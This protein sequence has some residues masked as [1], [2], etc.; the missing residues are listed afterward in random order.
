LRLGVSLSGF[1][2][3]KICLATWIADIVRAHRREHCDLL[4]AKTRHATAAAAD[5]AR[6]DRRDPGAASAVELTHFGLV[7][8]AVTLRGFIAV[9]E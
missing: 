7:D 9:K 2:S 6:L 4:T 5:D 8:H 3:A 1:H